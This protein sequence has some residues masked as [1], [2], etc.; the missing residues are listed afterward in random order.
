M[1]Q[2]FFSCGFCFPILTSRQS[3]T[4]RM[5]FQRCYYY[6]LFFFGR[7]IR[8]FSHPGRSLS[9]WQDVLA[10]LV[11]I[12]FKF[13]FFYHL[14][15]IIIIINLSQNRKRLTSLEKPKS[16]LLQLETICVC[17]RLKKQ[18]RITSVFFICVPKVVG[19][20]K[21]RSVWLE[22]FSG[23]TTNLSDLSRT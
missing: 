6:Y 21:T 13:I 12:L 18:H 9:T 19:V 10:G 4:D 7:C 23:A 5:D 15:L 11:L 1:Y 14:L 3:S 16:L 8:I 17:I 22:I 2:V 20:Q